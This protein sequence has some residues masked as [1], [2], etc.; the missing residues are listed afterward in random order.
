M[1]GIVLFAHGSTVES[2]NDA[3]RSV[4]AQL[5]EQ[6]GDLVETAFL[7][8]APPTLADAVRALVA[9]GVSRIVVIPYFLTLG[10]HLQRDLPRIADGLRSI[11]EGVTIEITE[12]LDGHPA[13]L[14]VLID[15]WKSAR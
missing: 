14:E 8:C 15:R 9:E 2:A 3:V 10:I 4:T 11:Y 13:L 6:T 12:P 1:T 7:D 5:A